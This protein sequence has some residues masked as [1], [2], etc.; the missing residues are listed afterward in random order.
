MS[1]RIARIPVPS[2][3]ASITPPA[4]RSVQPNQLQPL[5]QRCSDAEI[6]QHM[7]EV[8]SSRQRL[9]RYARDLSRLAEFSANATREAQQT[10]Q[11]KSDLLAVLSHE[12][13]TPLNGILGM[14]NLLQ[15]CGL[16]PV[17]QDYVDVI[18]QAGD[19]LL[20]LID[21]VLDFSKIEAERLEL[22]C[23]EL[24]VS[25]VANDALRIVQ[26]AADRKGLTLLCEVS[27]DIP[28]SIE[29]DALRIRQILLNL[30]SNAIKFTGQGSIT[31][32]VETAPTP[33]NQPGLRFTVIDNG[34]GIT[35]EGQARLFQ[36]FSQADPSIARQFGGTGLGLA[37][38]KRLAQMMG[39]SIGVSSEP[40]LGSSFWFI[41]EARPATASLAEPEP[42][43]APARQEARD[44]PR[45]LLVE[46]NLIN[47]KVACLMLKK[48]GYTATIAENGKKAVD[49]AAENQYDIIFMDCLMPEMD[50]FQA[51][52]SIRVGPNN[53]PTIPIVAMTANAFAKDR[54]ACLA[55]GMSDYL[56]KP[57]REAELRGM[58]EKWLVP[59]RE[60]V[61]A[62]IA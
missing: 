6:L 39:G 32:R 23:S 18:R 14:A 34:I 37:I 2:L 59:S 15:S 4:A 54:E 41:I 27:P 7:L 49:A 5:D 52:R 58:L 31:L 55:A 12:I 57:V 13:R 60:L 36:P 29:G 10:A 3:P 53:G 40:G 26:P 38:C 21:D 48:L 42:A 44:E 22:E 46:D 43:P 17:E 24:Q 35:P 33:A 1:D 20:S 30:L 56:P 50:G 47:Q 8:E 16:G 45:I 11:K 61:G 62:A 19:S 28:V 51:T 25:R 9:E